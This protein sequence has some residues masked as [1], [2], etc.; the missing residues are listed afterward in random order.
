MD[1]YDEAQYAFPR[2]TSA[3][4]VDLWTGISF[5]MIRVGG[6][7]HADVEPVTKEDT[8]KFKQA[9]GGEWSWDRRPIIVKLGNK[10]V[11]ASINGMPHGYETIPDNGMQNQVCIHFLNS[12]THVRNMADRVHQQMVKQAAGQ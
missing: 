8:A 6:S 10:W 7:N 11:A 9:Y 1:W 12:R 4:C 5:W 2:M 3:K